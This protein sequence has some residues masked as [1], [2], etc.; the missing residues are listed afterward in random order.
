MREMTPEFAVNILVV[1]VVLQR[2]GHEAS[3]AVDSSLLALLER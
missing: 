3:L 1:E 2:G